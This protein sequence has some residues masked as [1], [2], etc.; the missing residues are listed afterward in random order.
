H[1][2]SIG[3]RRAGLRYA[4]DGV[5]YKVNRLDWHDRL[6]AVGMA[7]RWALAHKFPAERAET[8][9]VKIDIQVGRTG[10]LT[11]GGRLP[12]VLVGGAPVV[13]VT[14]HNRD[15]IARL[16]LGEGDRIEIQRAGDV[17]PQAVETLTPDAK[18]EPYV[19][20]ERC[21]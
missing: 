16:G 7:P 14:V 18:R 1:Y 15:E 11:P 8:T 20:P 5:V 9:L 2:R 13:N 6:G 4:I 19:L 12:P 3:E 10:Q 17:I 21:P